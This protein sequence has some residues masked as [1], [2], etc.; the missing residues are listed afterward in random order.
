MYLNRSCL[1]RAKR[2]LRFTDRNQALLAKMSGSGLQEV[3]LAYP[4]LHML[5]RKLPPMAVQPYGRLSE[6]ESALRA[7]K[8]SVTVLRL[9]CSDGQ[10]FPFWDPPSENDDSRNLKGVWIIITK[11][12]QYLISAPNGRCRI[13]RTTLQLP[14]QLPGQ[15]FRIGSTTTVEKTVPIWVKGPGP[16]IPTKI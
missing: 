11:T 8:R 16:T 15:L 10:I 1:S 12:V 6:T 7:L 4:S 2:P 14:V 3:L 9:F 13:H 5:S